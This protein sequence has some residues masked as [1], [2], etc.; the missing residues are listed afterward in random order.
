M[1]RVAVT[2][3][4]AITPIGLDAPSTWRAAVAGESGIDFIQSFDASEFPVRI[5]GEV[6]GFDPAAVAPPKEGRRM[7]RNVLLALGAAQEAWK[8]AGVERPRPGA[9]RHRRR[10]GDRRPARDRRAEQRAARPR[11]RPRLAVLHPERARRLG[12]RP[13]RDLARPARAQLRPR[14]GLRDR[15]ARRRGGRRDHQARRRRRGARRRHRVVHPPADPR[16]LLRDARPRRRGRGPDEGL[17]PVRRDAGGLRH[18]GGSV[19]PRAR[20]A[21]GGAGARRDDL[22]RGA[23]LRR[24]E[25][26]APHGPAGARGRR[27][28]RDDARGAEPLGRRAGARRLHQRAR[29]VDAARR[30]GRDARDQAGLR[31]PRPP[32]RDLVDEVRH[33]PLLRS[34]RRD[35]VDDVRA[36]AAPPAAAAD[37]QLPQSR[38]GVR[39]RLRPERGAARSSSTWRSR[40]RWA[41]AATTAACCSAAWPER[42]ALSRCR[43]GG[44]ATSRPASRRPRSR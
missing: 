26:R 19:H 24:L 41:S 36:R 27:R 29:H 35:R 25:R 30:R 39:P 22:R 33:R 1:R 21:R 8:D 14:L 18:V 16:R 42:R 15:L 11:R 37:D 6:K 10:L 13:D 31:R 28:R 2:G 17:A 3:L 12:E 34:R 38:S 7:D 9:R 20:G 44:S 43:R 5:A 23:R 4:G 32:A 40:T